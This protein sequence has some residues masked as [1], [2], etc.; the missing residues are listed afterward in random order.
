MKYDLFISYSRKDSDVVNRICDALSRA[1]IAYFRDTQGISLS[2]HFPTVLS[3]AIC[4]SKMVL[5]VASK[6]SY[7]S[8]YT[9]KEIAFAYSE[10]IPVLPYIIDNEPM[11]RDMRF[12]FSNVNYKSMDKCPIEPHL[13][14][15]IKSLLK[16]ESQSE[17]ES[18]RAETV[19]GR[20]SRMAKGYVRFGLLFALALL[21]G[22][23]LYV[24]GNSDDEEFKIEQM[25]ITAPPYEVGDLYNAGGLVGVVFQVD[26]TGY[27][28]KIVSLTEGSEVWTGDKY[29]VVRAIGAADLTDGE[30]NMALVQQ[31]PGWQEKYPAFAWCTA[32]GEGWYLPAAEELN[33][34]ITQRVGR[35]RGN[36]YN[37]VR[38]RVE[39]VGG[40]ELP[41]FGSTS[42][43]YWSS[44][45]S[46][47]MQS[48]ESCALR[49]IFD[50]DDWRAGWDN[51]PI[52]KSKQLRVRAVAKFPRRTKAP[53]EVGDL[54]NEGN[55]LGVVFE[56]DAEGL[57]GKAIYTIN[58]RMSWSTA[59]EIDHRLPSVDDA[60]AIS[61]NLEVINRTISSSGEIMAETLSGTMW[62]SQEVISNGES[63]RYTIDAASG[64]LGYDY[65][66]NQHMTCWVF[67]F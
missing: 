55:L 10:Q 52:S 67:E 48:G 56:V 6:N 46:D 24:V 42:A 63:C 40:K 25:E 66:H 30:P 62:T 59:D 2:Q 61:K 7:T 64:E 26:S 9:N 65:P 19:G 8:S 11:P 44:T 22:A 21:V 28:G 45:E 54:Y 1:N 57:H 15:E 12:M 51:E 31:V 3:D 33:C 20:V 41:R 16:Q 34:M 47:V 36:L 5:F 37:A 39:M 60:M 50:V 35:Y 4:S 27:S 38:G 14:A 29:E 58:T 17:Q 18:Q 49:Y 13:V 43:A 32:Q 23:V 53:Y